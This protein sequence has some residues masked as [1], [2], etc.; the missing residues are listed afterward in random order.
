MS[1]RVSIMPSESPL[2]YQKNAIRIII[3]GEVI[4]SSNSFY[5]IHWASRKRLIKQWYVW[6]RHYSKPEDWIEQPKVKFNVSIIRYSPRLIEDLANL[7]H[8]AD[9]LILD[10]IKSKVLRRLP[11]G[12]KLNGKPSYSLRPY[13]TTGLIFD[14]SVNYVDFKCIQIKTN[15]KHKKMEI[16]VERI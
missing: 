6:L 4:P 14:D 3:P 2:S 8:S 13:I 10:N 12:R 7:I 9:K 1:K 16:I 11:L 5:S 15:T